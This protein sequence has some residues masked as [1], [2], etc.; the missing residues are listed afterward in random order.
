MKCCIACGQAIVVFLSPVT[1]Q[2]LK[3]KNNS[4]NCWSYM[5]IERPRATYV[6]IIV[7]PLYEGFNSWIKL[8]P[9]HFMLMPLGK[10]WINSSCQPTP[11]LAFVNYRGGWVL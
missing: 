3:A 2:D 8:F 11:Y 4:G 7:T 1:K 10:V 5:M 9:F 6:L